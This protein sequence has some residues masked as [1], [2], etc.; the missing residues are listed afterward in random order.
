MA[1]KQRY[2]HFDHVKPRAKRL[3]AAFISSPPL[4]GKRGL[5]EI[6]VDIARQAAVL[7]VPWRYCGNRYRRRRRRERLGWREI[8]YAALMPGERALRCQNASRFVIGVG[9]GGRRHS[10]LLVSTWAGWSRE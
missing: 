3:F 2:Q 1:N 4:S 6:D 5:G 8:N 9:A 10:P 7:A